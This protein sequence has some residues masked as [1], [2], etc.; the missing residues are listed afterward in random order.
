MT[1]PD[2]LSFVDKDATTLCKQIKR[3]SHTAKE[4]IG[5]L[6]DDNGGNNFT[7]T[8]YNGDR[9]L[10]KDRYGDIGPEPPSVSHPALLQLGQNW[11]AAMGGQFKGDQSCGCEYKHASWSGQIHYTLDIKGDE[12]HDELQDWSDRSFYQITVTLQDGVG[13]ATSHAEEKHHRENRHGVATGGGA[14][15]YEK[16]SSDDIEGSLGGTSPATVSVQIDEKRGEYQAQPSWTPKLGTQH[17][18]SCTPSKGCTT[19]DV[20]FS[21]MPNAPTSLWG[22]ASDPNHLQ[23]SRTDRREHIGY[24]KKGV[25]LWTVSWDLSRSGSR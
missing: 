9:A 23:G 12:G 10:D 15:R 6:T 20:T 24:S 5:H 8:A 21:T 22:T 13:T 11:V 16:E 17:A 18:V 7:A 3:T 19:K 2:F 4:F 14:V 1:A 25:Y